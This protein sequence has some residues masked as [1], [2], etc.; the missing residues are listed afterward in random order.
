MK[1]KQTVS[2]S[3]VAGAPQFA[4]YTAE[5]SPHSKTN[6]DKAL[7]ELQVRKNNWATLD[8]AGRLSIL[9]EN[10]HEVANWNSNLHTENTNNFQG[11]P[12]ARVWNLTA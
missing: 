3:L 7:A 5:I 11:F 9:D 10:E 12:T 6:I 1:N 8:I 2:P 4:E